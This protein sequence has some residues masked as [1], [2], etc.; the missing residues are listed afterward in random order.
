MT[1]PQSI[2]RMWVIDNI[3]WLLT[4]ASIGTI[5][6]PRSRVDNHNILLLTSSIGRY[7]LTSLSNNAHLLPGP[8]SQL[9]HLIRLHSLLLLLDSVGQVFPLDLVLLQA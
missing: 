9:E 8:A 7:L 1:L 5:I 4:A 6:I 2:L 3:E